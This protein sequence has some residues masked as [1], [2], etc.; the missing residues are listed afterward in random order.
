[1]KT[2]AITSL[3][4]GIAAGS[5]ISGCASVVSGRYAD[6]AVDSY[7]TNSHVIIRDNAGRQ[8]A[9]LTTP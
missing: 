2:S 7:P 3:V 6:V 5:L 1:M 4:V 9:S 8:V